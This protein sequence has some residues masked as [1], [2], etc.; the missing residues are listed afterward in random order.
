MK[1]SHNSQREI[2]GQRHACRD[3]QCPIQ[4]QVQDGRNRHSEMERY[5]S[6]SSE[7]FPL[8]EHNQYLVRTEL[9]LV[10]FRKQLNQ[11]TS[12]NR[13]SSLV[14]RVATF[15]KACTVVLGDMRNTATLFRYKDE[16]IQQ[17]SY[18]NQASTHFL[19][20]QRFLRRTFPF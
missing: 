7:A 20:K 6:I 18:Y 9:N 8:K 10:H 12:L 2:Q 1:C 13:R 16:D 5:N 3:P 11:G 17:K 19:V 14:S 4:P 15:L